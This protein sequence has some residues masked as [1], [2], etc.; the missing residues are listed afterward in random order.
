LT[1]QDFIAEGV[2]AKSLRD[3]AWFDLLVRL[4]SYEPLSQIAAPD[5]VIL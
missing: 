4:A 3:E 2:V 1:V 5:S